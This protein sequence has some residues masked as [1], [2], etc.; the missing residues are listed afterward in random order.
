MPKE[1]RM[2]MQ[3]IVNAIM[4]SIL[5]AGVV[6]NTTAAMSGD[7]K[8]DEKCYGIVKAK[9]N[10]CGTPQHS[11]AGQASKNSDPQEWIY[12]TKGNCTRIVDGNLTSEK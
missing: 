7:H 1:I 2:N 3:K 11:C 9:M 8:N 12:V 4:V 10:D 5:S 6:T